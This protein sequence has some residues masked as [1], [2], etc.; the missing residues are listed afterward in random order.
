MIKNNTTSYKIGFSTALDPYCGSVGHELTKWSFEEK[1]RLRL[2][3]SFRKG[4]E[5]GL[6]LSLICRRE[7][8]YD[9]A[10]GL[11]AAIGPVCDSTGRV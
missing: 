9:F 6:K 1:N 4:Y 8:R 11:V 2:M 3:R 10:A 5:Y 7:Q